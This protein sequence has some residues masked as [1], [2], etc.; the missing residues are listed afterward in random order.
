DLESAFESI[1]SFAIVGEPYGVLYATKWKRTPDGS[2]LI[3]AN[4]LPV[5]DDLKGK[6]GD[7]YPDWLA[8]IGNTFTF[9][10]FSLYALL[11]IREGG[12]LWNG[13]VARLNRLGRTEI[14]ADR[15]H[16][17]IVPGEVQN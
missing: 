14:S 10:N 1:G 8:G 7:P 4:G 9:K 2:I 6:V 5:V 17:Y 11:D 12:D 16:N 13:T 3:G 15:D